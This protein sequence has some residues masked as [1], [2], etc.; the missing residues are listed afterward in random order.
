MYNDQLRILV[1]VADC[2]SFSKA[3]EKLFI[4]PTAVMKQI[5]ALEEHLEL[6]LLERTP[7]GVSLTEAGQ[8]IYKDTQ[9]LF[10]FSQESVARAHKIAEMTKTTFRVGTSMLNPCKAFMELWQEMGDEFPRYALQIV[11]FEDNRAG[12]LTEIKLLG[13]KFD[14]LIGACDS[15]SWRKH[16]NFYKMGEYR[17]CCAVPKKHRLAKQ[18][19]ITVEQLYGEC[20]MLGAKGDSPAV[21]AVRNELEKHP[22]I[23]IADVSCFYDIEVFNECEQKNTILLTLECWKD[24]HPSFVTIP[25]NWQFSVPYGIMYPLNANSAIE[26]FIQKLTKK[27]H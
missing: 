16:C 15:K 20:I 24:I 21:D 13:K 26:N 4:S 3:S 27:L 6:K 25:V 11:P 12:I 14:F 7:R 9:Y 5:N 19:L 17:M 10:Q 2:G 18:K 23:L 1:C 22:Q 8:S